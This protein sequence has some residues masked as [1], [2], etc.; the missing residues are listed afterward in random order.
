PRRAAR[1]LHAGGWQSP[2]RPL[3]QRLPVPVGLGDP[4]RWTDPAAAGLLGRSRRLRDARAHQPRADAGRRAHRRPA[5]VAGQARARPAPTE[6]NGQEIRWSVDLSRGRAET[7]ALRHVV[8]DG[9]RV[10]EPSPPPLRARRS[11]NRNNGGLTATRV[12]T[13]DELFNRILE[14][15]FR[16]LQ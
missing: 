16:D 6:I 15:S 3:L 8:S 11:T 5:D 13:S 1:Q 2:V 10:R 4:N 14:R 7:I 9:E 12:V